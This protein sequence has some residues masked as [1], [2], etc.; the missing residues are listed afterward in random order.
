MLKSVSVVE[1]LFLNEFTFGRQPALPFH[2]RW[3]ILFQATE[4]DVRDRFFCQ[5]KTRLWVNP[6]GG[7]YW[8]WCGWEAVGL[9]M[10]I[11]F[12]AG[13]MS[14][15]WRVG[16]GVK[17]D[18]QLADGTVSRNKVVLIFSACVWMTLPRSIQIAPR[19]V[20]RKGGEFV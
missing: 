10:R 16:Y 7:R 4:A 1:A 13:S 11:L 20:F 5:R 14:G 8:P 2:P 17:P 6:V 9:G 12:H 19:W 15:Q 3:Q 18:P